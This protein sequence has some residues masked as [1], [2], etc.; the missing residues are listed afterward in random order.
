MI[1]W[2]RSKEAAMLQTIAARPR[3][4][5][6]IRIKDIEHE[7]D[8]CHESVYIPAS[9]PRALAAVRLLQ[10]QDMLQRERVIELA[11][12]MGHGEAAAWMAG[13]RHLYF[14]ALRLGSDLTAE[15][16][17]AQRTQSV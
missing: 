8:L 4:S 5:R 2:G 11:G 17:R 10:G 3:A 15:S 9:V 14:V 12:G 16:Q 13:H 7:V 6:A 1:L